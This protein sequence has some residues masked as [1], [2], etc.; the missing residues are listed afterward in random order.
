ME[1]F[2]LDPADKLPRPLGSGEFGLEYGVLRTTMR[3][4]DSALRSIPEE[5]ITAVRSTPGSRYSADSALRSIPEEM[6]YLKAIAGLFP[7]KFA[8]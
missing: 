8:F 4:Q 1:C 2:P 6:A 3:R 7:A 5:N